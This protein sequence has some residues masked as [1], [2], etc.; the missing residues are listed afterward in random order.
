ML[1]GVGG[2]G[3]RA[4]H[5]LATFYSGRVE[6]FLVAQRYRISSLAFCNTLAQCRVSAY[7]SVNVLE[8]SN[9][10]V[11][12]PK[13]CVTKFFDLTVRSIIKN[14]TNDVSL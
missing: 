1:R 3:L 5:G 13:F 2:G 9:P 4:C 7:L 8:I 6:I 10:N 12:M 14:L 11:E